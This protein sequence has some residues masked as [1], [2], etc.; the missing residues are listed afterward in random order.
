MS[1]LPTL[2]A[3]AGPTVRALLEQ[4]LEGRELGVDG[5]VAPLRGRGSAISTRS[6][7]RPT[8][9]GASRPATW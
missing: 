7:A 8:R 4:T 5:A 6:A 2:L 1:D 3:G 9:S